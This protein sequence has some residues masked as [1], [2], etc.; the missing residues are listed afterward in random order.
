MTHMSPPLLSPHHTANPAPI[1]SSFFMDADLPDR[2]RLD[3]V[4]T[5]VDAKNVSR[6]LDEEKGEGVVNEAMEQVAYADRILLNKVDLIKDPSQLASLEARLRGI[7]EMATI[8][9][10]TKSVV[11]VDFV[12]GVGGFDLNSIEKQLN[13]RL[14]HSHSHDHD[15]DHDCAGEKC[16]HES[17]NHSHD[18]SAQAPSF[19]H[20]DK[21]S[22]VSLVLDGDMDLDKINYSLGFLLE[23]RAEDIF[24]MKGILAIAGS[25]YRF[26]YHG[27]HEMFEG[28]PDRKWRPDEKRNSRLVFIGKYL[29]KEDFTEAFKGCMAGQVPTMPPSETAALV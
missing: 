13:E 25:D 20:D 21:V 2:V 9:K 26:V 14:G 18:H 17:H 12:L 3:G 27:V 6:H 23:S 28:I 8:R 16:T 22:S 29:D 4:V 5:V 10:S 19:K 1:I 11:D 15:H 24:R 7:N